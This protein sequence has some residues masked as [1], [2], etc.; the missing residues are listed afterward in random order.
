MSKGYM[1][2]MP[3]MPKEKLSDVYLKM[4]APEFYKKMMEDIAPAELTFSMNADDTVDIEY[5]GD[6]RMMVRLLM[7]GTVDLIREHDLDYRLFK[8]V[9]DQ[10]EA[11]RR[12]TERSA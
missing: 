1:G 5:S 4:M 11:A 8:E 3:S 7:S 2:D 6:P 9:L 10:F 12:D